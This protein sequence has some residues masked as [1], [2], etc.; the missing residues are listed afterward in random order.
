MSKL[1]DAAEAALR[2]YMGVQPTETVLIIADEGT[3]N[4]GIALHEAGKL[5]A[6]E[7][8]YLEM[9]KR[10]VN[11][12]EPPASVAKLMQDVDA[13]ICATT[14]SLTHTEARRNA[15]N[16]GVRVGTMPGITEQI[17]TRCFSANSEDIIALNDKLLV[18]LEG[19]KEVHLT[20]ASGTDAMFSAV[21]RK[22][23]SSTGVHRNKGNWG[24]LPSGEVYFAPVEDNANGRLVCDGSIAGIGMVNEPVTIDIKDGMITNISGGRQ[25]QELDEMLSAVGGKAKAVA[26]FGI[27]T[28]PK[29]R[30][31]GLILE[32]EK[33]KGTVH[34]A[35][36]NN[37]SM[38]GSI[39]VPI[40]IDCI[41]KS[42]SF[43]VD[44]K[45]IMKNGKILI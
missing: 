35:F 1:T 36:G 27:G 17:L 3:C 38:E 11:G 31:C 44:G 21:G 22:I 39:D 19:A 40:H 37:K 45:E 4:I 16:L 10:E 24:N 28:N 23:I 25:A 6:K 9:K 20:S 29:A 26:E 18:K 34:I 43:T 32:D 12:Q 2:D 42:P 33:V 41:I 15:T 7:S 8:L 5:I 14:R 30:I 13:V